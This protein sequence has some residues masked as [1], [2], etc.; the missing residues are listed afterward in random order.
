MKS[1][2][3]FFSV[4]LFSTY[5]TLLV[6]VQGFRLKD[7]RFIETCSIGNCR[8]TS[9]VFPLHMAVLK[10]GDNTPLRGDEAKPHIKYV[11]E[12]GV[13]QFL[14]QYHKTKHVV[15]QN[16]KWGD[17]VEVGVLKKD[18][19][20]AHFDLSC[21]APELREA[22]NAEP[23]PDRNIN[24]CNYQPE[25]G[26]WM[27]E[28]I[29]SRPYKGGTID[30]LDVEKNMLLRRERL[31]GKLSADEIIPYVSNF[32][33]LGASGYAHIRFNISWAM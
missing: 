19:T 13:E 1:F 4:A 11:R 32:P 31:A 29:P 24:W 25:Y 9:S 10:T 27:I 3:V 30:L 8:K 6:L 22:L 33:M 17:E 7:S 26:S 2:N 20:T 12:H 16:F 18:E 21:R 23:S 14:H 15:C 5:G 28:S